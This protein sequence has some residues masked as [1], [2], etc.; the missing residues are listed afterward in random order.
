MFAWFAADLDITEFIYQVTMR[1]TPQ[2]IT[3]IS[4]VL[5]KLLNYFSG[6]IILTACVPKNSVE[7]V[8]FCLYLNK[9]LSPEK[10]SRTRVS[11]KG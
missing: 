1:F 9:A 8:I 11:V 6:T 2:L 10:L 5:Q 3:D 7:P 4:R